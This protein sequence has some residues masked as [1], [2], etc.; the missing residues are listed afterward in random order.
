VRI[1]EELKRH[2]IAVVRATRGRPGV[3][4]GASPRA[5]LAMMHA[6]RALALLDGSDFATPEHVREAAVPVIAH[7]LVLDPQARFSGLTPEAVVEEILSE[8]PS[9]V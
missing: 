3:E 8:T 9:P 1:A 4:L 2:I 6:A 5:S 7:R